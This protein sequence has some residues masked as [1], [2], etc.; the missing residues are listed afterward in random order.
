MKPGNRL[1]LFLAI[2]VVIAVVAAT[3]LLR[4]E[5]GPVAGTQADAPPAREAA[6]RAAPAYAAPAPARAQSPPVEAAVVDHMEE[7]T[8]KR[9]EQ[10]QRTAALKEQSAQ[11][12]ASEQVDP[13]W[14][15]AKMTELNGIAADPV[16]AGAG[17]APE[18]LAIDCRSSMCRIDG[19]FDDA[20][21]AEDWI[22]LYTASV[23]SALPNTVISRSRNPDGSMRVEIYG[24]GR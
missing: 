3:F 17:V 7:R 18:S 5:R 23:G 15:P 24:R 13:N 14:A 11:R 9:E 4:G 1:P 8:R 12:F 10:R 20:S 22:M 21:K 16:I 6:T 19:R 2:A